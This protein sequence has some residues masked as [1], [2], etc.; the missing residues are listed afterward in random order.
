M[1]AIIIPA[2]N[3][4]TSI[5]NTLKSIIQ[6][7][8][9]KWV[10]IIVDDGSTDNTLE[11]IK[12]IKDNRIK[13]LTQENSGVSSARN[14]AIDFILNDQIIRGEHLF[15]YIAFCDADDTWDKTHLQESI[16]TLSENNA[17]IC[18]CNVKAVSEEGNPLYKVNIAEYEN[19]N[20]EN[21]KQSNFIYISST[22]CTYPIIKKVKFFDDMCNS[23][24]DYDY[25]IR[26]A[27][28]SAK[29]IQKENSTMTYLVR[30]EGNAKHGN[31]I[32]PYLH[33]KH[34][35]FLSERNLPVRLNLGCGDQLLQGYINCDMYSKHA[36][37]KFDATILPYPDNS[38]DEIAAYHLIEH[39]L[40]NQAFDVLKEW[41]RVLKPGGK[42]ILETPD[43]LNSCKKFVENPDMRIML[44]SHFF[45]WPHLPGQTHYFLYTEEQLKWTLEECGYKNIQ[46]LQPDSIY[47]RSNPEHPDLYLKIIAEK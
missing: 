45:A 28:E 46:R 21:L 25:W 3:A 33:L 13:I 18:Y 37:Q 47:A 14:L 39:F 20:I 26:C 4:G 27:K 17:D 24:E 41:L 12:S 32:L 19:F 38:V 16:S 10:A 5:K 6:Q 43:F 42:L 11:I 29:F 2:Y 35:D 22:V 7:T 44:Y 40:F 34:T 9:K 31:S 36:Q 8:H 23:L 30:Q 15:D 1:I